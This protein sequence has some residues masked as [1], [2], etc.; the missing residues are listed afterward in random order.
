MS[1]FDR[2]HTISYSTSIE[3]IHLSCTVR[4][5]ASY[6]S[7]VAYFNLSYL[8]LAHVYCGQTVAHLSNCWALGQRDYTDGVFDH[9]TVIVKM[10]QHTSEPGA[11]Q[12]GT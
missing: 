2:V 9:A 12:F 8:R 1:P 7:K 3:T 4:V 6:L 10:G 11:R 5:T